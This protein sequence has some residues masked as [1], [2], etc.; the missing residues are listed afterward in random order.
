MTKSDGGPAFPT[1]GGMCVFVP[2]ETGIVD[3]LKDQVREEIEKPFAGMTLRDWFAGQA[4]IG[5]MS[6]PG[7]RP[8][9]VDEFEHM[10]HR[11]YQVADAM[12]TERQKGGEG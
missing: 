2:E 11:L 1:K 10:A 12:L 8:C 4:L 5:L 7:L 6:D 3:R 9:N